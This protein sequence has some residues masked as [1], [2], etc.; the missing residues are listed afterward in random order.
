MVE[1]DAVT[2]GTAVVGDFA[3]FSQLWMR[4][5]V[6]VQIGF[7]NTTFI[8]GKQVIRATLRAA[9][10]WYRPAAFCLVTGLN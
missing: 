8:E 6:E 3:N 9:M 7:V 5:G 2:L 4:Q 1:T 10:A